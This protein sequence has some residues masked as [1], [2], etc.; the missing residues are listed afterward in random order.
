MHRIIY[1]SWATRP[2]SDEQL[3]TLLRKARS[4]NIEVGITGFLLY[5]NDC[6]LQV[7]EGE[8]VA[9]RTLYEYIKGDARHRDVTAYADK[10]IPQR[11]FAEWAM[12][13]GALRQLNVSRP[14]PVK[15][16]SADPVSELMRIS[17]LISVPSSMKSE[18]LK[19]FPGFLEPMVF[20]NSRTAT[21]AL[22]LIASI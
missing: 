21:S 1:L 11:A 19:G 8:E 6:F 15:S 9:V 12:A 4:R 17:S 2:F 5:G 20:N 22:R 10:P 18:N 16:K 3:H 7:L 13:F 14:V